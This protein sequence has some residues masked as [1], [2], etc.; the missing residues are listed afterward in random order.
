MNWQSVYGDFSDL[1]KSLS[2]ILCFRLLEIRYFQSQKTI[3]LIWL[4]KFEKFVLATAWLA[5]IVEVSA[6]NEM[7]NI[8]PVK[9]IS[10]KTAGKRLMI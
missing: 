2:N 4:E 9:D 8:V 10:V 6:L 3:L 7:A 5:F 1:S